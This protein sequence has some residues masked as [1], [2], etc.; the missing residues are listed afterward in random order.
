MNQ[1]QQSM[2]DIFSDRRVKIHVNAYGTPT[3]ATSLHYWEGH[4]VWYQA[5]A[6]DKNN[7]YIGPD[8]FDEIRDYKKVIIILF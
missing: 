3:S 1:K 5:L 4:E 2:D 7:T 8:V 6:Q